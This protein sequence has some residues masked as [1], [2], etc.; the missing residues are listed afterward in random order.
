MATASMAPART[1]T[2]ID[3]VTARV[4]A[5]ALESIAVEMGHKLARMSYSSIIRESED[6]GCV[7]C[8]A[9]GRQ[10]AESAQSTPLQSGPI[11]GYIRGINRRFAEL[12]EE[13]KPGDVVM[14]NHAYYGASHQPD[15]A[16]CV[17]IFHRS[18]LIGYSATT[19]HHLD[20]GALTPG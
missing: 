17:P 11:P 18:E 12:G 14:H 7:I 3:P 6:F 4:I 10:L 20:L 15:V 13:W 2:R 9:Q 1:R 16:L 19:A 8:D 5:G